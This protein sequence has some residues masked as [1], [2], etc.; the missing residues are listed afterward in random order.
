MS[1]AEKL[2]ACRGMPEN[3]FNL[4]CAADPRQNRIVGKIH[5]S[6]LIKEFHIHC[7]VVARN[8]S[9]GQFVIVRGDDRSERVPLTIA[10]FN[11]DTGEVT[12]VLQVVGLASHKLDELGEGD[13]IMD[14]VGPLGKKSEIRKF[15]TV[16][17]VA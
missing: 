3:T 7:P 1:S 15:G 12:L 5:H 13:R 4:L 6:D 17:C 10:D 2:H 16:V 14:V 11:R 8:A 9:P